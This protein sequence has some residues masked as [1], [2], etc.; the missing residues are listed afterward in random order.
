M[1]KIIAR[2]ASLLIDDVGKLTKSFSG[3]TNTISLEQSAEAPDTTGFG[4]VSRQRLQDGIKDWEL[5]FNSFFATGAS[6]VDAV[7]SGILGGSTVMSFGPSGSSSG[8]K[9]IASAVLTDYTADFAV[10]GA[11]TVSGTLAAR[12]GSM[13]RTTW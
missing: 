13:T 2:D 9:Y 11:A 12:S 1:S 4:E 7:L 6:E 3:F 5:T 8:I 10:E